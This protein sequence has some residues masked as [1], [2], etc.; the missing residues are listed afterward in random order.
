LSNV[1]TQPS[2]LT[3]HVVRVGG[4]R[5]YARVGGLEHEAVPVVLVHGIGVSGAYFV[6]LA[7]DLARD[8]PVLAPDL[9]GFGRSDRPADVPGIHELADAL[10]A[11][12]DAVHL[13]R[14]TMVGNSMGCQVVVDL[15]VR[16]AARADGL[17]LIS[18]T[19]DPRARTALRQAGRLAVDCVR[20]PPELLAIVARDY[21]AFGARRFLLTGR[22]ALADPIETKLPRL[23]VPAL[24][25]RGGRD[26][27]VPQRWAEEAAA[28][29]PHGRLETVPGAAHACHYTAPQA[30]AGLVRDLR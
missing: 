23:D 6:A 22:S 3:S 11:W 25:I 28:L 12:L 10:L 21:A 19:V 26:P 17:V 14:A 20:E 5:V 16:H 7:T 18:P 24:V 30:V 15:L 4:L 2:P 8:R 29:L 1:A 27:V 9:P 13:P